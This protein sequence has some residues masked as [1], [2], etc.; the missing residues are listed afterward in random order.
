MS[1]KLDDLFNSA[2]TSYPSL[3]LVAAVLDSNKVYYYFGNVL[4]TMLFDIA[5]ITKTFTAITLLKMYRGGYVDLFAPV[6]YYWPSFNSQNV[7]L[8]DL[9]RHSSGIPRLF[10]NNQFKASEIL[11]ALT[12][13]IFKPT[14]TPE[15]S[16]GNFIALGQVLEQLGGLEKLINS[17]IIKPLQLVNTF[18]N[19]LDKGVMANGCVPTLN[20]EQMGALIGKVHDAKAANL[21]GVAGHAGLFS[22]MDAMIV[23]AQSLLNGKLITDEDDKLMRNVVIGE[24]GNRFSLGFMLADN[25]APQQFILSRTGWTG[26]WL[27]LNKDKN[28][29]IILLSNRLYVGQNLEA[30]NKL[31]GQFFKEADCLLC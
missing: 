31:R 12:A 13:P 22:G 11:T 6:S 20:D 24:L 17:F 21:G 8:I 1:N 30:C 26:G 7:T 27:C 25:L 14:S 2:L 5:S 10:L 9:L 3:S 4:G 16:D 28:Y 23:Y 18:F 19:P 29:A 15:Y